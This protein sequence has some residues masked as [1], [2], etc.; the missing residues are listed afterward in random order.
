VEP[1]STYRHSWHLVRICEWME[2]CLTEYMNEWTRDTAPN[3]NLLKLFHTLLDY[4]ESAVNCR[5]CS[6]LHLL[7]Q[8]HPSGHPPHLSPICPLFC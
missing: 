6:H 1:Y 4:P 3:E 2:K 8:L 5:P 7:I